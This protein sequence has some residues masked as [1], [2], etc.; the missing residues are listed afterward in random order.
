MDL[1]TRFTRVIHFTRSRVK[2]EKN[3]TLLLLFGLTSY[4][5]NS[6][7]K[8]YLISLLRISCIAGEANL[9]LLLY[10]VWCSKLNKYCFKKSKRMDTCRIITNLGKNGCSLCQAAVNAS[11]CIF[12]NNPHKMSCI[13]VQCQ[14]WVPM[15]PSTYA[16]M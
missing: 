5:R 3:P 2:R 1:L 6:Q 16:L 9:L 12:Q 4:T 7:R 13:T 8:P 11:T 10:R 14:P 15:H